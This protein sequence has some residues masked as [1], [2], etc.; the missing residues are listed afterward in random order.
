M[1]SIEEASS[2]AR[3][4]G[5]SS[6]GVGVREEDVT[7]EDVAVYGRARR[8]EG[9]RSRS[10][11]EMMM[12]MMMMMMMKKNTTAVE[13]TA[14]PAAASTATWKKFQIFTKLNLNRLSKQQ[15]QQQPPGLQQ[16]SFSEM[17]TMR[18]NQHHDRQQ[19]LYRR[20]LN[21]FYFKLAPPVKE[22]AIPNP[23]R[24]G[25]ST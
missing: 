15:Q 17:R 7:M 3:E 16:S 23:A 6:S 13:N 1:S 24:M 25:E 8:K 21:Y 9:T 22:K 18:R 19:R 20:F 5:G 12:K 4:H 11:D 2:E 10:N 14:P